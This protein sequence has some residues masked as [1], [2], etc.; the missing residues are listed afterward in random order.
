MTRP[1][2]S[3]LIFRKEGFI[4]LTTLLWRAAEEAVASAAAA[5]AAIK[6]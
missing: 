2:G 3:G 5:L 4:Q 6:K 1:L